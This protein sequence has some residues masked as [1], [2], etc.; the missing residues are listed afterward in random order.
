MIYLIILY[1]MHESVAGVGFVCQ[2]LSQGFA[3]H[4]SRLSSQFRLHMSGSDGNR[5]SREGEGDD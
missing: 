3:I 1:L 2:R 4:M 5:R